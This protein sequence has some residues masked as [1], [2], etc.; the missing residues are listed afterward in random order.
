MSDLFEL[1]LALNL[2]GDLTDAEIADLR[3]HL[4]LGAQ[5]EHL[6]ILTDFPTVIVD[7]D[8][9]PEVVNEPRPLLAQR[10]A[11]GKTGGALVADLVRRESRDGWAMTSRQE[12]HPDEFEQVRELLGWLGR[13]ADYEYRDLDGVVRAGGAGTVVGYLRFHEDVR[14]MPLTITDGAIAWPGGDPEHG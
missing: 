13:H 4:G 6:T 3:W 1:V 14:P 11:A 7:E 5:P 9:T 12:L 10:G 8:G 2:R